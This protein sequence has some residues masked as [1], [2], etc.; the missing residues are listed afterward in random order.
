LTPKTTHSRDHLR[1]EGR[2]Q[3]IGI[4]IEVSARSEKSLT[5]EVLAKFRR[6]AKILN[7]AGF[8]KI[9]NGAGFVTRARL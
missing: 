9:L 3:A 4:S 8:A 1:N 2:H 5:S 7:G 6:F